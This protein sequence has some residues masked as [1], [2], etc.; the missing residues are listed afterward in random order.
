MGSYAPELNPAEQVWTYLTYGRLANFAPDD[1]DNIRCRHR[2][3]GR[4]PTALMIRVA[5]VGVGQL[6]DVGAA[7]SVVL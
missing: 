2:L 5:G 3:L 6:Q 7:D 1:L 4:R